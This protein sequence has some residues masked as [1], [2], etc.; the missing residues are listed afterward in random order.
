DHPLFARALLDRARA[1]SQDPVNETVIVVAHGKRDDADNAEWM[2]HLESIRRQMQEVGSEAFNAIEIGT[3]REDWADK[4]EPAVARIRALIEQAAARGDRVIIVP[5]RT[6]AQGP[7]R[8]LIPDLDYAL[9]EGFAGHPLFAEWLDA[10]VR[11]GV[12][13]IKAGTTAAGCPDNA[14]AGG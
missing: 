11:V 14:G 10:Q 4:R 8:R 2:E 12:E 13:A 5:A 9:A 1:L 7:A 6:N 3:W